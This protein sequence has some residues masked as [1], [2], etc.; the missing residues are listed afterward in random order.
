MSFLGSGGSP[1]P[2]V[3][4]APRPWR[5][6]RGQESRIWEGPQPAWTP[7]EMFLGRCLGHLELS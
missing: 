3:A 6:E 4:W 1:T 5:E 7:R 2:F